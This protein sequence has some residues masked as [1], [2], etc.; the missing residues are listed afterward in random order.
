LSDGTGLDLVLST[1]ED[2][3]SAWWPAKYAMLENM[4]R[5]DPA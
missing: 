2:D 3:F 5:D 4:V 1:E